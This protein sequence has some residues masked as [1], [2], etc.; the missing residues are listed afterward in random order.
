M[1]FWT[2]SSCMGDVSSHKKWGREREQGGYKDAIAQEVIG[3]S[4]LF[5]SLLFP[6]ALVQWCET[7]REQRLF[8]REDLHLQHKGGLL[9]ERYLWAGP[10]FWFLKTENE[11]TEINSMCPLSIGMNKPCIKRSLRW[12]KVSWKGFFVSN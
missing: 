8:S 9:S 7:G 11:K 2:D 12:W 4:S 6:S 10:G 5:D 1:R 3:D